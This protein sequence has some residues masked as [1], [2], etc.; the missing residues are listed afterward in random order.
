M[1]NNKSVVAVV[2]SPFLAC[3]LFFIVCFVSVSAAGDQ[4]IESAVINEQKQPEISEILRTIGQKVSDFKSLKTEFVQ[5]KELAMFRNK[6]L[7][8]GRIYLQKP[9]KLAW[10]VDKPVRYSVV[11]TDKMIRQWDEDTNKIQ[12]IS[13]TKNLL[14]SNVVKQLTVWFSGDYG[15]LMDDNDVRIVQK[16]PL[17]IEFNPKEKNIARKMIK[18]ITI[19]FREDEKYLKRIKIQELSGDT[20]TINFSNTVIDSPTEKSFF[21]VKRG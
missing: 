21:E 15:S 11:I 18:S 12:E 14:F 6:I 3:A 9:N 5:E 10:H 2:I 13:L 16:H 20:T 17:V 1:E 4:K 8:Q 19:T 7:L